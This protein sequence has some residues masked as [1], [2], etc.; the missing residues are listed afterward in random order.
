MILPDNTIEMHTSIVG[1]PFQQGS[2]SSSFNLNF[3]VELLDVDTVVDEI[4]IFI[5]QHPYDIG[6]SPNITIDGSYFQAF[7]ITKSMK[8]SLLGYELGEHFYMYKVRIR[9]EIKVL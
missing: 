4:S 3:G 8:T 6:V 9:K 1:S 2:S 7:T 5:Y